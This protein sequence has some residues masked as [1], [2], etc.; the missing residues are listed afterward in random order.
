MIITK[1]PIRLSLLG[2]A[3]DFPSFFTKHGGL[4]VGGAI[5]KYSYFSVNTLPNFGDLKSRFIYSEIELCQ[6]NFEVKH[7]AINACLRY[8]NYDKAIEVF[9]TGDLP[10]RSGTGS[11]STF[12]VG[13]LNALYATQGKRASNEELRVGATYV[14]Q[15]IMGE[16]VGCQDQAF[17]A[18]GGLN[19][20][21]FRKN[22]Y[23]EVT[24]LL[25]N[26]EQIRSLERH[27]MMF[28]TGVSRSSNT[29][30]S[31]YKVSDIDLICMT[32]LAEKGIACIEN[33]D[34]EELGNLIDQSWRIKSGFSQ[35]VNP[36]QMSQIYNTARVYGAFG[37]KLMG[38]GGGG[39][40]LLVVKPEKRTALAAK[41]LEMGATEVP[42]EFSQSGSEVIY[43]LRN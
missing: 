16:S 8:T 1:T 43:C 26:K 25:I 23:V 38:A 37:G 24:P 5:D 42:F 22:G 31:D 28:Y 6:S 27:L 7:R 11:S 34:F 35:L 17:A 36:P 21:S 33:E 3:T 2:G 32:R 29:I 30:V 9:H 4:V 20:I 18:Y 12:C 10:S 40:M 14:E 41:M 13:L 39:M 15:V 19:I